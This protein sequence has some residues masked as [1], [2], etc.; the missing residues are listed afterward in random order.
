MYQVS[1]KNRE[2][3][4]HKILHQQRLNRLKAYSFIFI[5][6]D[7]EDKINTLNTEYIGSELYTVKEQILIFFLY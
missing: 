6:H 5:L 3:K 1:S 4:Y 2:H 7:G